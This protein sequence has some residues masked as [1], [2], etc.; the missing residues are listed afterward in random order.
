METENS[1]DNGPTPVKNEPSPLDI[2]L[3]VGSMIAAAWR[4]DTSKGSRDTIIKSC[5]QQV[6]MKSVFDPDGEPYRLCINN[7]GW[8]TFC[9][10]LDTYFFTV[11]RLLFE[12]E[13]QVKGKRKWKVEQE[14]PT[15]DNCKQ[16][17]L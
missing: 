15:E 7:E 3:R 14:E 16:I 4:E 11:K 2:T 10:L 17:R 6:F 5:A 8:T 1:N 9:R 12:E 13:D